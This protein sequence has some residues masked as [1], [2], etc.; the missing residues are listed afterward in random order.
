MPVLEIADR[1]GDR[2]P[3]DRL[4]A[5]RRPEL[6]DGDHDAHRAPDCVAPHQAAGRHGADV[7]TFVDGSPQRSFPLP[8]TPAILRR[9]IYASATCS[10]RWPTTSSAELDADACAISRVIG[11]VLISSPSGR[12]TARAFSRGRATSCPTFRRRPRCSQ[13]RRAAR[14][15][16]RRR[17]PR[18]RRGAHPA[19]ATASASLVMLPLELERRRVGPRRGLPRRP[20]PVQRGGDPPSRASSAAST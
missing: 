3:L 14:A 4:A 20:P 7:T 2:R 1:A 12:P 16:T 6:G 8:G 17:G 15:H 18:R 19:R 9:W 10:R 11:D 5:E 13:T